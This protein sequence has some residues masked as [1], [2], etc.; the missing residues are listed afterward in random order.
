MKRRIN[1]EVPDSERALISISKNL[2]CVL[3]LITDHLMQLTALEFH[4]L[5]VKLVLNHVLA[6]L[7]TAYLLLV[8]LLLIVNLAHRDGDALAIVTK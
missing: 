8:T 1:D 2:V 5:L 3:G 4:L 6:T 7:R